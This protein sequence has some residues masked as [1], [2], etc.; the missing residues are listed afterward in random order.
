[1]VFYSMRG[2]LSISYA[3]LSSRGKVTLPARQALNRLQKQPAWGGCWGKKALHL[4]RRGLRV[5]RFSLNWMGWWNSEMKYQ[6]ANLIAHYATFFNLAFTNLFIHQIFIDYLCVPGTLL[7]T[8]DRVMSCYFY[9][10]L[11]NSWVLMLHRGRKIKPG[12]E[13][14]RCYVL[15]PFKPLQLTFFNV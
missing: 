5:S 11:P 13:W 4:C 7:S 1:M 14:K 10:Y 3:L 15:N 8:W 2:L 12:K 6:E 9:L